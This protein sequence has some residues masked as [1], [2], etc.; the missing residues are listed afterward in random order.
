[1]TETEKVDL[2]TV[3]YTGIQSQNK[4]EKNNP[5]NNKK[6]HAKKYIHI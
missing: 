6:T 1:M 2:I 5:S 3:A 4:S